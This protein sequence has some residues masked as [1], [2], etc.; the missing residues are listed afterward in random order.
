MK[1]S[2]FDFSDIPNSLICKVIDEYIKRE[3]YRPILKDRFTNGTT[4]SALAERYGFSEQSIKSII[5]KYGDKVLLICE[6]IK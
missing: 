2:K 1:P 5:L 3:E 6:K 4:I